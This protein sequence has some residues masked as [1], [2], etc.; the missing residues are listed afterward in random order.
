M[1]RKS[2]YYVS[3]SIA[4]FLII[5]LLAP[6]QIKACG[7]IPQTLLSLYMNSKLVVVG[8]YTGDGKSIK[9]DEDEYGY[10]L[11]TEQKREE[12]QI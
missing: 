4:L 1:F 8:T 10:S 2:L 6:V 11:E 5:S 12:L 7:E 9:S 3:A